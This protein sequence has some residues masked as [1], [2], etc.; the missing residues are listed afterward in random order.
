MRES[1]RDRVGRERE[2][3]RKRERGK[4][5]GR[6]GKKEKERNIPI[7]EIFKWTVG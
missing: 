3:E 5:G 2:G 6:E 7:L 4:T 1:W